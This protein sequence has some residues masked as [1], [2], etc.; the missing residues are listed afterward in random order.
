MPIPLFI[1]ERIKN[2]PANGQHMADVFTKLAYVLD[3]TGRDGGAIEIAYET[4]TDQLQ[5][6]DLVPTLLFSLQRQKEPNVV[7]DP[8]NVIDTRP[9]PAEAA[10]DVDDEDPYPEE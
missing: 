2:A 1:L 6:G 4:E 3:Q 10:T 9:M 7:V 8:D 5:A